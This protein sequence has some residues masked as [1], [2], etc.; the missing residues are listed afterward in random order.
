MKQIDQCEYISKFVRVNFGWHFKHLGTRS[1]P[2]YSTQSH[3][4]RSTNTIL[5]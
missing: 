4:N 2:L 3:M 1:W 5:N